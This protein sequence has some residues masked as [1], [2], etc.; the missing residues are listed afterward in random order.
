MVFNNYPPYD[1]MEY[2]GLVC[3]YFLSLSGKDILLA[4]SPAEPPIGVKFCMLVSQCLPRVFS[5]KVSK[6]NVDL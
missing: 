2:I 4:F 6:V 5:H 3:R 1:S